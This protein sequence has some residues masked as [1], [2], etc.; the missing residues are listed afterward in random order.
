MSSF[1]IVEIRVVRAFEI[2]YIIDK[3]KITDGLDSDQIDDLLLTKETFWIGSLVT[4]HQGMNGTHDW[5]RARRNDKI[6]K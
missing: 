3:L 4:Q 2:R 5:N 6:N 1:T